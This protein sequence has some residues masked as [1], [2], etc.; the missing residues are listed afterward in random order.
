MKKI[1]VT[2]LLV[3]SFLHITYAQETAKVYQ[4]ALRII[5]N[6]PTYKELGIDNYTT[7]IRTTSFAN[8]AY[9]FWL[10]DQTLTFKDRDFENYFGELYTPIEIPV[11][12]EL[13]T[14]RRAKH[15]FVVTETEHDIFA[16][17]IL[18]FKRKRRGKYPKFY[19]GKSYSFLFRKGVDNR[20]KLIHNLE[21]VNN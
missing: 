16:I 9:A 17:E 13:R 19:Q 18:V 20:V 1:L 2:L 7:V 5:E 3:T 14:K 21:I 10:D 15:L 8:Q 4:E 6:S 11:F 12:K